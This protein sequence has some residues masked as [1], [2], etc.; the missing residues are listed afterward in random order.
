MTRCDRKQA[1]LLIKINILTLGSLTL[2]RKPE[3]LIANYFNEKAMDAG[4]QQFT[5]PVRV[6]KHARQTES[7]LPQI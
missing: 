2:D 5:S 6:S 1:L 3:A 7:A 4:H